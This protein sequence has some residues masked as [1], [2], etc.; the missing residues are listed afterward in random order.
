MKEAQSRHQS[1]IVFAARR[2]NW[3]RQNWCRRESGCPAH[4]FEFGEG[5]EPRAERTGQG[6]LYEKR[7]QIRRC[8]GWVRRH[9]PWHR[10]PYPH[11][12][13]SSNSGCL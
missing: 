9:E 8:T 3:K 11:L 4:P 2:I 1:S 12:A 13:R 6:R 10:C 7:M 5:N